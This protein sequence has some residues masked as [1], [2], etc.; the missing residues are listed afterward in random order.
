MIDDGGD[1]LADSGAIVEYLDQKYS[2]VPMGESQIAGVAE[3]FFPSFVGF[4]KS[5]GEEAADK[6]AAFLEQL[7]QLETYLSA[8]GPYLGGE[9]LKAPDAMLVRSLLIASVCLPNRDKPAALHC[10][11][12]NLDQL[13]ACRQLLHLDHALRNSNRSES[14]GNPCPPAC[15][16]PPNALTSNEVPTCHT[17]QGHQTPLSYLVPMLVPVGLPTCL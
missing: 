1:W 7:K 9:Q 8:N 6:E 5:S 11:P 15:L 13:Y 2:E 14:S 17:V 10:R 3:K 4:L 12:P 16:P